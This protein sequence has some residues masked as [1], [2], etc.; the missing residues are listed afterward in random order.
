MEEE[1]MCSTIIN[2]KQKAHCW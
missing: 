1:E 2:P